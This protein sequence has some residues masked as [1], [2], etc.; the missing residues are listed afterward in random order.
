LPSKN[1][2]RPASI[3]AT[4]QA[5]R[6]ALRLGLRPARLTECT[7]L[8]TLECVQTRA[9]DPASAESLA[10]ALEAVLLDA[11]HAL[12]DGPYG[13]AARLLFGAVA[14]T[15]GRPLKDRRRLAADELD[16]LPSTFRHNYE[17]EL[18]LDVAAE[19]VRSDHQPLGPAA[20]SA[21]EPS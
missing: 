8:L 13:R 19:I 9:K 18:L 17:A 20:Q 7:Q 12:G 21:H 16:L 6:P 15:R 11:F 3:A 10:Y 4:A 1:P 5:L 14:D 2:R